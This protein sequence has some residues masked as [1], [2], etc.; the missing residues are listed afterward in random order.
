LNLSFIDIKEVSNNLLK[1]SISNFFS[2]DSMGLSRASPAWR[3]MRCTRF[4][5]L[6][7]GSIYNSFARLLAIKRA[8][9]KPVFRYSSKNLQ[10]FSN[11]SVHLPRSM[12]FDCKDLLTTLI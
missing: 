3:F 9:L 11:I 5:G 7:T 10:Q 12:V 2:G 8:C 1:N 6:K 4:N